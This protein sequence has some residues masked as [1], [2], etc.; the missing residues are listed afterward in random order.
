ML[1]HLSYEGYSKVPQLFCPCPHILM[2]IHLY[3]E[4]AFLSIVLWVVVLY[5]LPLPMIS[6]LL[7]LSKSEV[8]TTV[9]N[10]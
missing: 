8:C 10:S 3:N 1:N 7:N 9:V 5:P 2:F 6:P 4:C